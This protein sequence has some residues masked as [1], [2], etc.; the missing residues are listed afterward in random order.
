VCAKHNGCLCLD[1]CLVASW[2]QP[3]YSTLLGT[4][5][6]SVAKLCILISIPVVLLLL[7]ASSS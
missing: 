3:V 1:S 7:Q 5:L 2:G 6:W 4:L